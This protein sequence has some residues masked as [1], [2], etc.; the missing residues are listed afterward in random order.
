MAIAWRRFRPAAR[1]KEGSFR[2][3][4][5]SHTVSGGT[6]AMK[7]DDKFRETGG[8]DTF[9]A[10]V[11]VTIFLTGFAVIGVVSST[12][13]FDRLGVPLLAYSVEERG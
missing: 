12:S 10:W 2:C 7:N 3:R 8:L 9:S 6:G 4:R 5:G 11:I 13:P 1:H